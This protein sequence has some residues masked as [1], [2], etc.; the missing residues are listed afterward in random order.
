M[1]GEDTVSYQTLR[2]VHVL[3]LTFEEL[4]KAYL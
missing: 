3:L 1:V 2:A 4:M